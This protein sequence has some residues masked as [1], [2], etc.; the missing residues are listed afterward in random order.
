V[1]LAKLFFR[2]IGVADNFKVSYVSTDDTISNNDTLDLI[3]LL[4]GTRYTME[5]NLSENIL[6]GYNLTFD[7]FNKKLGL[8][9]GMELR[10]RLAPNLFLKGNFE[11][12][13][14]EGTRNPDRSIMIQHQFRF[15]PSKKH[16]K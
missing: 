16:K 12:D 2:K 10:Y 14:Q 11:F 8:R 5:K 15:V 4:S 6:L 7:E 3:C 9:H 13:P 1:P